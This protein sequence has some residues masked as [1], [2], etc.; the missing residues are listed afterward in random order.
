MHYR[1]ASNLENVKRQ[2][3]SAKPRSRGNFKN[4]EPIYA[5]VDNY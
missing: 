1:R 3:D 5:T 2:S 4:S